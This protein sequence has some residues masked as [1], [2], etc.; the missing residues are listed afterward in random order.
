M[1][2]DK[3]VRKGACAFV[4]GHLVSLAEGSLAGAALARAEDHLASCP[5][6]ASL[7]RR[8]AEAWKDP[9]L[10][11]D[12]RPSPALLAGIIGMIES[13][14]MRRPGPA[15]VFAI[16]RR[17]RKPAAVAALFLGGIFAGYEMGR[18]KKTVPPPE[19]VWAGQWLDSFESIPPGSIADFYI[20]R[21]GS[22]KESRQ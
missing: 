21:P 10:M 13:G 2:N 12:S 1:K 22:G 15:G 4:R 18:G 14:R 19:S 16:I 17:S 3:P 6:C 8:F 20:Q 9:A 5:E 11:P 7:A